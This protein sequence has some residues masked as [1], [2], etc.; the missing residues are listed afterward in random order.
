[1]ARAMMNFLHRVEAI[2]FFVVATRNTYL[3]LH[4]QAGEQLSKLFLAFDLIKYKRLCPRYKK[5][6]QTCMN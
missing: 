2:L 4:L 5:K 3:E 1:M 6:S